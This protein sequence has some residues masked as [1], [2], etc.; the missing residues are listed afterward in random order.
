[1]HN[2]GALHFGADGDL[3]VAAG[4]NANAPNA[5]TLTNLLGKLLRI[6]PD[7]SI[8]TSNPFYTAAT[9]VNRAIW[10]LGLRNPFTFSVEPGTGRIFINN[11]GENTWESIDEGSA[12][13]N[14]GWPD[15]EGNCTVS[16]P[17]Y[18][19]PLFEYHHGS[20]ANHGNCM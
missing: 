2:G 7:G 6:A 13:A 10:A 19:D 17:N 15:C 20:A 8:P 1:N 14:Y 11:V 12:G 9:G 16:N 3:Y 4:E 18:T 5:Q